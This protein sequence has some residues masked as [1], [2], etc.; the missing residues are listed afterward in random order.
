M[1]GDPTPAGADPVVAF[2]DARPVAY[3]RQLGRE[4]RALRV[5]AAFAGDLSG[6]RVIDLAAGTGALT[7]ALLRGPGVP[8]S[9]VAVDASPRMLAR[10]GERLGRGATLL[11]AD[12]RAVPVGDAGA[13]VVTCGYLLHL[14][15]PADRAAVVAEAW[16]LLR[17]GGLLVV[18]VHGSPPGRAGGVHRFLWRMWRRLAP[19]P[20]VV[21]GGPLADVRPPLA[22]A[23]F[24]VEASRRV[25]GLYWSQV[26]R[27]RRPAADRA[28]RWRP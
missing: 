23:G 26:V 1:D 24:T 28:N 8:A 3:D 4:R 15:A 10:A 18:V 16:R 14:L 27:C 20:G 5:A 21:G 22:D 11:R 2:F 9:V 17:P 12:A 19:G 13:D 7:A 25:A 6:R